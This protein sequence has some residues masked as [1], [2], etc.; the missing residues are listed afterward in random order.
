[1]KSLIFSS[2]FTLVSVSLY[3]QSNLILKGTYSPTN[4][5][6]LISARDAAFHN[7]TC[8]L[9]S[10]DGKKVLMTQSNGMALTSN[11]SNL[12]FDEAVKIYADDMYVLVL[13]RDCLRYYT[14]TE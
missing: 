6:G 3:G 13:D 5:N 12:I 4:S 7:D 9:V 14:K 1:M 10:G 2:I 8:Y 11:F